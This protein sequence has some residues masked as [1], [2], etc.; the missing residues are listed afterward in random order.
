MTAVSRGVASGV[1]ACVVALASCGGSDSASEEAVNVDYSALRLVDS[2]DQ[3]L[4]YARSDEELLR[5][6]RNG[7]RIMIGPVSLPTA[8]DVALPSAS[9]QL[10]HSVTTVQV[11]GVD[12]ADSV[13]YDG[14]YLYAV[15]PEVTIASSPT[16]HLSRNVLSISRTDPKTAAVEPIGN[17][18]IEGEQSTAP[19]LY[20]VASN[21]GTADYLLAVSQDYFAWLMP[22]LPVAA[23]VAHPDRTTIQWLDV[24][25]PANVSQAWKL[26]LD[27]WMRA[28]R[29]TGDTLYVV[30]S[31]RPRM[32]DLVWPADTLEKREA[33]ERSI[34]STAARDLLPGYSENGGARQVLAKRDGCLIAQ[35]LENRDAYF[36][37]MVISAINVRTRRVTDVNCLSTNV[38]AV[39]VSRESL[40]VAG[41]GW[42]ASN[43]EPIT[44][45]HKFELSDDEITYRAT[46]AVSGSIGWSNPS[47]FMDEHQGDL[48]ILTSKAAVHRLTV[49]RES[50]GPALSVVS[51]IPNDA[52]PEP[53]GK[54]GERVFAVRFLE[55]RAYVVTFRTI[56]PLYVIDLENPAEPAIAGEL[57]V[58][59]F[60]TSL[61]PL[62][63][64]RK[65]L[66]LAVGTDAQGV[67]VELF[68]VQ[69]IANPRSVGSQV[70]GGQFT[71]SEALSDP[72]ALTFLMGATLQ[73]RVGLPIHVFDPQ[74]K[75]SGLHL[76]EVSAG[77]APQ[78]QF[79]GVVKTQEVG[80]PNRGV[81][82]GESVFAIQGGHITSS[83]WND[84]QL[85]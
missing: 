62:G 3:P 40:Y 63:A 32:P 36:D 33:N 69:D 39:Y 19:Q 11:E 47:Y 51:S 71:T 55:G 20:Q 31:Y 48:R 65:E 37:L 2:R 17:Y 6:L 41:S 85:P 24:R 66:L 10:Q 49:L 18:V 28:S 67:K 59:G 68:D 26:E 73:Y 53:I 16:P 8:I 83:L 23:L 72:H 30:S 52:H 78:L 34:R 64:T 81:L 43:D 27:G 84:I 9:S 14:R 54:P 25:D 21:A 12:E 1:L 61:W 57:E 56:D 22:M 79:H 74:W 50:G 35:G 5:P 42:Q 13:K 60:S 15:Q 44:V 38:N 75:Y 4:Q 80:G 29:L 76:L 46:G 58:P 45:L 82:H 77:A 7:L 70:F